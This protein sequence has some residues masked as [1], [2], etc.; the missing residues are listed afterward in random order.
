MKNRIHDTPHDAIRLAASTECILENNE[1]YNA[2]N[3]TYDAGAIYTGG[4][5]YIGTANV[6]KGNYIHD[7]YLTKDAK[8]GAVMALYWD[9]QQS[10][11]T[12]VDNIFDDNQFCMLVGGGDWNTVENNIFYNS[13]P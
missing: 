10:G 9:D 11:N 12:A 7:I 5:T 4:A 3:D 8:G 13:S 6:Y 2:A 1:V